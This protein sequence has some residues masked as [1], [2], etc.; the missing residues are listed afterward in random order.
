[1]TTLKRISLLAL[2]GAALAVAG[3]GGEDD[4][5]APLPA[6]Q[7]QLLEGRLTET[8]NRLADGSVGA[9]Q[10]ILNDTQPEVQRVLDSLP[11]DV[12][13]D[14]RSALDDSY[15]RLWEI[16]EEECRQREEAQPDPE[17]EPAPEETETTPPPTETAPPEEEEEGEGEEGEQVPPEE[18]PLPPEGDGNNDGLIPEGGQ[19]GGVGP[20][21]AG[22]GRGK[23]RE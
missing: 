17:P 19:G 9:C 1:M 12:D 10:D 14:V 20:G 7:V 8:E 4:E 11:S 16:V 15:Q 2:L 3:C 23:G 13:A 22:R 18:A 21:A 6:D 5:G